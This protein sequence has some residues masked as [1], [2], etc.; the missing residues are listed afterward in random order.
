MRSI[1]TIGY[2]LVFILPALTVVLS[3]LFVLIAR[4]RESATPRKVETP[5]AA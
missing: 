3:V 1:D 4:P 5:R 2:S